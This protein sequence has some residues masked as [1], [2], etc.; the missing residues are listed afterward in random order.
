MKYNIGDQVVHLSYGLGTITG[1]E[2]RK[3]STDRPVQ[4]FYILQIDDNGLTK[5]VF[6]PI[7]TADLMLR[8][9]ISKD[10]ANEVLAYLALGKPDTTI[11][12]QTWNRRYREYMELIHTG[13]A[14]SVAKVYVALKALQ[15]DKDL[16]F[17]E[18]KLMEQAKQLLEK[19][20]IAVGVKIPE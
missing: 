18:R 10:Q 5:K 2:E 1:I 17:G 3:F 6:A 15:S 11:D 8:P 13:E 20:L 12:H 16:S 4:K 7:D 9:L 14:M 19:E